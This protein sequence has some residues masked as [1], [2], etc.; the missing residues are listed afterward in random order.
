MSMAKIK[1]RASKDSSGAYE[2]LFE[3]VEFGT[4]ISKIQGTTISS[5]SELEKVIQD[6]AQNIPDLDELVQIEIIQE[7]VMSCDKKQVKNCTS[8]VETSIEPDFLIFNRR[9]N[10]QKYYTIE[11]KDGHAFDTK[12]SRKRKGKSSQFH[13]F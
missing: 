5:G 8:F 9:E 4:L 12:K 1:D 3:N 6:R 13:C 11:P 2:R 7:S 10:K